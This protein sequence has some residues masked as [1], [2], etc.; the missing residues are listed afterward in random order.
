VITA[1]SSCMEKKLVSSNEFGIC[2]DTLQDRKE[3][4]QYLI[5][6]VG[7]ENSLKII[8]FYMPFIKQVR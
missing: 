8:Q 1:S 5:F 3:Q 4:F 6:Y 2:Y 7:S